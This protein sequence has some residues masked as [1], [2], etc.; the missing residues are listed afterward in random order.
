MIVTFHH[1]FLQSVAKSANT[2]YILK[3]HN[4]ALTTL[5]SWTGLPPVDKTC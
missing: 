1:I 2:F 3:I 5:T 4:Y